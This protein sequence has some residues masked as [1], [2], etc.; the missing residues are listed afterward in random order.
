MSYKKKESCNY[1]GEGH[2]GRENRKFSELRACLACSRNYKNVVWLHCG[3]RGVCG[4]RCALLSYQKTGTILIISQFLGLL[5][6]QQGLNKYLLAGWI[7]AII[8]TLWLFVDI[9]STIHHKI[10]EGKKP[11]EETVY[12]GTL[13]SAFNKM[14]AI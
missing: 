12:V 3:G 8:I 14:P 5:G 2:P 11:S 6:L 1:L 13:S 9:F 10:L 7:K 4:K